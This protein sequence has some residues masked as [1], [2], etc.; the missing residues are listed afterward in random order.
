MDE[1][2]EADEEVQVSRKTIKPQRCNIEPKE[3]SNIVIT[4]V[5]DTGLLDLL[6]CHFIMYA[7][8]TSL[9]S[10]PETNITYVFVNLF[11]SLN[12]VFIEHLV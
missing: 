10:T 12:Q 8:V 6:W 7:N 11:Q 9:P 5:W 3:N 2:S 4:L 1:V